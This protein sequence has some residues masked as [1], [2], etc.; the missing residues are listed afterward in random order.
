MARC[1]VVGG[2]VLWIV[3]LLKDMEELQVIFDSKVPCV[4]TAIYR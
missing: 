3:M 4:M 2:T 1:S